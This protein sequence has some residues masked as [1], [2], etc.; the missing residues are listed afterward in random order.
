MYKYYALKNAVEDA[1]PK[2]QKVK[3]AA[4]PLDQHLNELIDLAVASD[5]FV[6]CHYPIPNF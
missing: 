6:I 5:E 1:K 2:K 3:G 4:N